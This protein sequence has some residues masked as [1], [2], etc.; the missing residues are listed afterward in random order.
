[1]HD[2]VEEQRVDRIAFAGFDDEVVDVGVTRREIAER[3]D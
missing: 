3:R 1:M 2:G